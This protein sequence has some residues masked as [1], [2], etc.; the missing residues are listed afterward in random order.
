[1]E[2]KLRNIR[3]DLGQRHT[4][5]KLGKAVILQCVRIYRM[6]RLDL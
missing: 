3:A 5:S 6:S 1:M 2:L 4:I